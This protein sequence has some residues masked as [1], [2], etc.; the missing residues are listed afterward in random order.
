MSVLR[1]RRKWVII[2]RLP[3]DDK[4]GIGGVRKYLSEF[5]GYI[6][7][8]GISYQYE[9]LLERDFNPGFLSSFLNTLYM[10][11][12]ILKLI[13]SCRSANDIIMYSNDV[14]FSGIPSIIVRSL[15]NHPLLV[16]CHNLPS[17][18]IR[19]KRKSHAFFMKAIV[20]M[21]SFLER[22]V[23]TH[24]DSVI[25][26]NN[27][28]GKYIENFGISKSKIHVVPMAI[29]VA[30]YHLP[31]EVAIQTR[32]ELGIS[33]LS[34]VIG[35]IGRLMP[36]KNIPFLLASY[37]EF[38]K[39]TNLDALLIIIGDGKDRANV[40]RISK[41][42]GIHE[43]TLFTGFRA[44]IPKLLQ[45][46]DVFVLPSLSEGSPI[47]LL[48]AMAAGKPI[49]ASKIKANIDIIKDGSNGLLFSLSGSQNLVDKLINLSRNKE[50]RKNLGRKA[51]QM[52]EEYDQSIIFP[53]ILAIG[54]SV[55]RV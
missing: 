22:I 45:I 37:A 30:N 55:G 42:L 51:F 16:H 9:T 21:V 18:L 29:E 24:A 11:K 44:D 41:R 1:S 38:L 54:E 27:T 48:E 25:V 19:I 7:K 47:A 8:E 39:S 40:E 12:L 5:S 53:K 28:L 26:T 20:F 43:K 31:P 50:L 49:L 4:S 52:A 23:L 32:S 46:L 3:P 14:L 10:M 36:I 34:F 35:F 15:F 17:E 6:E 33:K 13:A 2:Y